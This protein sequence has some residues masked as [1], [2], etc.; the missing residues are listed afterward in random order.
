MPATERNYD[1]GSRRA[2]SIAIEVGNELRRARLKHG[3]S[4]NAVARAARTSRAQVSRI[5]RSS[6]TDLS[7]FQVSRLLAVVGLELGARAYPA[8]EPIRDAAH[9]A[10]IDRFRRG[11]HPDVAWHF[12]VPIVCPG[13]SGHG[14]R[15]CRSGPQRSPLKSRPG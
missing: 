14:M 13:I 9:L 2:R 1:R 8:G 3:L 4:Q 7:I 11:V 5:E 15:S 6:V 12:E 10:L